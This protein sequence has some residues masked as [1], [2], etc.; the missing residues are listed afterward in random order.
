M[1][2]FTACMLTKDL[3]CLVYTYNVLK[4]GIALVVLFARYRKG[5]YSM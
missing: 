1:V 5:Q 3:K 4:N 2:A